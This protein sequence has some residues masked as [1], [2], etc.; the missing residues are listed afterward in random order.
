MQNTRGIPGLRGADH[1]GVTVPDMDQA[2]EFFVDVLGCDFVYSLGPYPAD[3]ELMSVRLG[4]HP[5]SRVQEIR[6]YRCFN[7]SNFEVFN[8]E[9]PGKAPQ[10][11]KNSDIGGHH[12]ALYV[13]NLD[14][15]IAYLKD[16][17][18]EIMGDPTSSSGASAG[19][20]WVYFTAPW[21]LQFELVSF[22]DGKAYE[23]EAEVLL[24]HP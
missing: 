17:G 6:F 14:L 5:H 8:Y 1:F 19:Q 11:P 3:E 16:H 18:I 12:I 20:R 10:P 21:G 9:A 7:G 24:W 22:P 2:H 23:S 13:D 4:V 15:A